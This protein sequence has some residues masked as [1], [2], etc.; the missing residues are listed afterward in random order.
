MSDDAK[1]EMKVAIGLTAFAF[2]VYGIG[3]SIANKELFTAA[4]KTI[5][6]S[7]GIG[8]AIGFAAYKTIWHLKYN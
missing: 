7:T 1:R 4:F 8:A 6:L 5:T 3:K 2:S